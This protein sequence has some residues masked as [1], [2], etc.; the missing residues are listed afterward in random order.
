MS[1]YKPLSAHDVIKALSKLGFKYEHKRG[2]HIKLVKVNS[3]SVI[4][5][6]SKEIKPRTLSSICKQA[7]IT[8]DRLYGLLD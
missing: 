1:R 4:V 7:G 8:K 5:V 3:S 2:S 6:E